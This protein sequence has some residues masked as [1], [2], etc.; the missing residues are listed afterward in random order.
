VTSPERAGSDSLAVIVEITRLHD[1]IL[2]ANQAI[3]VNQ[4]R[5]E[6]DLDLAVL[7]DGEQGAADLVDEV[8]A[9]FVDVINIRVFAATARR[10]FRHGG[11]LYVAHAESENIEEHAALGLIFDQSA[12][13][14]GIGDA[15]IEIAVGAENHAI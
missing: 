7:G 8:F 12:E 9:G 10:E 1:A 5:I 14:A 3:G 4:R 11:I 2:V 15:D 13:L 6:L